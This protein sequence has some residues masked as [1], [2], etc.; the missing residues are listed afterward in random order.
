ME[1]ITLLHSESKA[2][3]NWN[4]IKFAAAAGAMAVLAGCAVAVPQPVAKPSEQD[5]GSVQVTKEPPGELRK[6]RVGEL[7]GPKTQ[8]KRAETTSRSADP[9]CTA[10]R[11]CAYGKTD[12]R[13]IISSRPKPVDGGKVATAFATAKA[14]AQKIDVSAMTCRQFVQSNEAN[15]QVVLAW[16]LGF[17]S[18]VENPQVIDLGKLQNFGEKLLTFCKEEPEFRMTTAAEGILGK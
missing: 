10:D 1:G 11:K 7:R 3:V 12:H 17:Y 2:S 5:P 6:E 4:S 14:D 18:E 16:F 13:V 9:A 8:T 15:S